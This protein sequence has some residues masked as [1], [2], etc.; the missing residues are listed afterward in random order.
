MLKVDRQGDKWTATEVFRSKQ[1]AAQLHMAVLYQG[2]LYA[3]SFDNGQQDGLICM[4]LAGNRLWKTLPNLGFERGPMLLA[5]GMIIIINGENGDL[6]LV[7][8]QPD[9]YRELARA[10]VLSGNTIWAP[11]ALT[12]GRLIVRSQSELKCLNLKAPPTGPRG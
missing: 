10:R 6:C 4:D 2:H 11:M 9:G 1:C 7:A 12:N 3:N 5:D 8:A